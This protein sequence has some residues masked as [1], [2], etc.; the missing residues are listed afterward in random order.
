MLLRTSLVLAL[1]VSAANAQTR[2]IAEKLGYPKNAKLLILH[3]DDLGAAHSI[4]AASFEAL[5]KGAISSASVMIPTP[6]ISEV[7]AYARAHPDADLGIHLVLTSEWDTYKWGSVAGRE[8]VPSLLDSAGIFATRETT[9]ADKAKPSEA[10]IELR[11]QLDRARTLGIRVTHAD[12]HMRSLFTT[13]PL[14]DVYMKVARDYRI[15][16]M[17]SR[18]N[19]PREAISKLRPTDPV[20]DVILGAGPDIPPDK[21]KQY[22]LDVIRD[23]KPGVSELIVHL[24]FDDAELKAVMVNQEPWG[25]AWRQRDYDVVMSPEFRKALK[26][27]NIILVKW[28]DVYRAAQMR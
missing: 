15:P 10:E 25:A 20:M 5:D 11:A 3:A 27:N 1:L 19:T 28:K 18:N 23:L 14:F 9:V 12:S 4:N 16:F 21:W 24:G 17:T 6:W 7:A 22:Y 13:V 26:D 8:K 2:T